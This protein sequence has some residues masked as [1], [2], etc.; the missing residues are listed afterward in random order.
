MA[1]NEVS[2]D[3]DLLYPVRNRK[4]ETFDELY[5]DLTTA[6]DRGSKFAEVILRY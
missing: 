4:V 3:P 2:P 5:K 1:V 6:T